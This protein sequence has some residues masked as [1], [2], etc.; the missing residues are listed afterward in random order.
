MTS[1]INKRQLFS[2]IFCGSASIVAA[3]A[4]ALVDRS[5]SR[6]IDQKINRHPDLASDDDAPV[7]VQLMLALDTSQSMSKKEFEIELRATAYAIN[8]EIFR[9]AIK[10]KGGEKSIAISV[11]DFGTRAY[12]RIPWLDIRDYQ[13][14]DKPY[15]PDDPA[16]SSAAPDKLDA[17]AKE[18]RDLP[19]WGSGGTSINTAMWLSQKRFLRCPWDC[20]ERRVLDIFGD[21][22]TKPVRAVENERDALAAIGVTVNGIVIVNE[23]PNLEDYY[24]KHVITREHITT[25]DGIE[26]EPGRIWAVARLNPKEKDLQPP[27]FD[28]VATAMKQ[29]VSIEVAGLDGFYDILAKLEK[30]QSMPVPEPAIY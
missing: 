3:P 7:G 15:L 12:N 6:I 10:Y 18:I 22:S 27:F 28:E 14:N 20:L 4:L 26:S 5:P 1:I 13:I 19:R 9:N 8:S 11:I 25:E 24:T 23:E 16:N 21:G 17:L 30:P 29:K 2:G